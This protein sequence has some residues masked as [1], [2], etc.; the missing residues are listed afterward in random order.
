MPTK[1]SAPHHALDLYRTINLSQ[2][3][4]A[5]RT[6]NAELSR[7]TEVVPL[8]CAALTEKK[9]IILRILLMATMLCRFAVLLCTGTN[10]STRKPQS[11]RGKT[12]FANEEKG[13]T[14]V[15]LEHED[16]RNSY[17][18]SSSFG[19]LHIAK[20]Y[21]T[22]SVDSIER[23]DY[24]ETKE[25]DSKMK[26]RT[27]YWRYKLPKGTDLQDIGMLVICD[28]QDGHFS[29]IPNTG[30]SCLRERRQTRAPIVCSLP[31]QTASH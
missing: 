21:S 10:V 18:S 29:L 1:D 2:I 17:D 23:F 25:P 30:H 4:P 24:K 14:C 22:V 8:Y 12:F 26:K 13:C 15:N 16:I 20:L 9:R 28:K 7:F 11:C 19:I 31:E 27:Y 6:R 3:H 5:L